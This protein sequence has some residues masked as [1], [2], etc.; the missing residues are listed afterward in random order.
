MRT[1]SIIKTGSLL[2]ATIYEIGGTMQKSLYFWHK[3]LFEK[4][5]YARP[6]IFL[7][8]L[9]YP[10]GHNDTYGNKPFSIFCM[11]IGKELRFSELW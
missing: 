6:F 4:R 8:G 2:G 10:P 11:V 7:S 1:G 5:L 9:D 3:A